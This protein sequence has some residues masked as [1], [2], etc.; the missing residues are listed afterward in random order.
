MTDPVYTLPDPDKSPLDG[1][2]SVRDPCDDCRHVKDVGDYEGYTLGD[3]TPNATCRKLK[4]E[5]STHVGTCTAFSRSLANRWS[6]LVYVIR[7]GFTNAYWWVVHRIIPKHRYHVVKTGLPPG[8]YD[9]C[10]RVLAALFNEMH[11]F[12]AYQT[13]ERNEHRWNWTSSPEHEEAWAVF[14]EAAAFSQRY[15]NPEAEWEVEDEATELAKKVLDNLSF[16]WY[17]FMWY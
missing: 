14:Q 10:V 7:T 1:F 8:Y 5:V 4:Q 11:E 17:S 16:M 15:L 2:L 9:P 3:T 6:N 13:D 12:V